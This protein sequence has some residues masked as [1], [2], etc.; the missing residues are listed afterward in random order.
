MGYSLILVI[1]HR[2]SG[3]HWVIDSL[4][5]NFPDVEYQFYNLDEISKNHQRYIPVSKFNR[6][7]SK[8]SGHLILK[9]HMTAQ[10]TPFR[11]GE[12]EFVKELLKNNKV[13]YVYRDGR[14]VLVSLYHYMRGFRNDLPR[15]SDF[16]RMENDFDCYYSSVNRIEYWKEHVVGWISKSDLDVITVSYEQLHSDYEGTIRKLSDFLS[17]PLK[18]NSID[19][20]ELKKYGI[21]RR[22]LRRLLPTIARSSAISPRKGVV[23][24]WKNYFSERDLEL[25]ERTAGDLM[26]ELAYY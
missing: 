20:I 14:D 5:N 18:S 13:I 11:S 21:F 9:S 2:R 17:L 12:R 26:K 7:I 6:K 8:A 19:R 15:F 24:D 25:F 22:A 10:L 1:S 23:G 16:I 3:T 4:R